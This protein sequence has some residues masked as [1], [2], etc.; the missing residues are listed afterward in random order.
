MNKEFGKWLLDIAKYVTTAVIISTW[1][2]GFENW[3][4]Y[5]ILLLLGVIAVVVWWGLS[6][7]RKDEMKENRKKIRR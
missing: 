3:E 5:Y 7:I 2:S 4:W 1:L 6:L